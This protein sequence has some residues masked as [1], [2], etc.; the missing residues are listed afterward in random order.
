[1]AV[2]KKKPKTD[3]DR[4]DTIISLLQTLVA[5]ELT[6][7]GINQ[8]KIGKIL[9]IATGSV[10]ALMKGYKVKRETE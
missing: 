3:S 8:A 9:G 5:V 2:R 10:N 4:L 7:G 6:K 1:M